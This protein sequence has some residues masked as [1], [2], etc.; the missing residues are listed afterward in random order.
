VA[1]TA[2]ITPLIIAPLAWSI[3]AF[4]PQHSPEFIQAFNDLGSITM[5]W[6]TPA[7]GVQVLAVGLAILCDK[8]PQPVFPRWSAYAS[9]LCAI[10]LQCGLLAVLSQTGPLASDG[11]V[12]GGIESM[13]FIPWTLLMCVFLLRAIEQ[14]QNREAEPV[15]VAKHPQGI[16][17]R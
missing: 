17:T 10:G 11:I 1:G 15:A 8:S 16:L 3:A 7:A 2:S 14:Q 9:F 4:R 13:V 6:A 12:S 5:I